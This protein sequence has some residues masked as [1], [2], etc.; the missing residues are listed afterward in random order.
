MQTLLQDLRFGLRMLAKNPGFTAVAMLTLAL[1]IGGTTAIFSVVYGAVLKPFPYRDSDR[2][3]MLTLH[4]VEQGRL[5]GVAWVSASELRAYREQ[6]H[7]FDEVIGG[8]PMEVVLTGSEIP[9]I[10]WA[11]AVTGNA[12][13]V[14]GVPPMIGRLITAED[15]RAGAPP[16]VLLS[17]EVWQAHFGGDPGIVGRT[18][19]LNQQPTTVIGVMPPRFGWQ[20][21][22]I[23]LPASVISSEPTDREYLFTMV[24]RLKQGV[25][26]DQANADVGV[27]AKR[28]ARIYPKDYSPET[29]V[30]VATLVDP[31]F[32]GAGK[33]FYILLGAVGVLLLIACGNVSNLL[34]SRATGREREFAVRAA[35]GAS[36][37][38]LVRQLLIEN[39][40]L[41]LGGAILGC[42]A[43]WNG[44]G[45]LMAIIPVVPETAVI[46]INGLVL[47]FTLGTAIFSTLLFGLVPTLLAVRK[48]LQ[49]Q[50]KASARGAGESRGHHRMRQVLVVSEVALSLVLLT[51]AGMLIRSYFAL[52]YIDLGYDP[53]HVMVAGAF[54]PPNQYKTPEQR[55]LFNM[56][57]LRRV[58]AL[59][60]VVSAALGGP[61]PNWAIPAT[62]EIE[63]KP[64][65]D[66]R[67][68]RLRFAGDG[69]F[70]TMRIRM[71]RGR[72]ISEEDVVQGRRVAVVSQTFVTS[73][74]GNENPLGRQ[75]KL[76]ASQ[77]VPPAMKQTGFE[78][79]GEVA[80]TRYI[81]DEDG[82]PTVEPTMF[83]PFSIGGIGVG[84]A[85]R[86]IGDP[87][88]LFKPVR[89]TYAAID[90]ELPVHPHVLRDIIKGTWFTEP[91]FVM[92]MLVAFASLGLTLVCI[93]VYSV[94]S[95]SVSQ[96]TNEIG[97][98]MALGAQVSEVRRMVMMS[99]LRWL[100]V[101]IGIGVLASIALAKILQNRI[102]GIKSAD[103]L[104]LVAVSLLLTLVG[105]AACY[106][107]ARRAT[108]VDPMV[109]LRYE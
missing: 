41:A 20:R 64:S 95:Y 8:S 69:F 19:I 38:R 22:E 14:L 9:E 25:S 29:T 56:E 76:V 7:V 71:L 65:S 72:G 109:A 106:F 107:P 91:Q 40:L 32:L 98:R 31:W 63:G 100:A 5:T 89:E 27:L 86:T 96:R 3:V 36:R 93:G 52:R 28:L 92:T 17:H 4:D 77:S 1:G 6:N 90:K 78:I 55:N 11:L 80:D 15:C 12:F 73:Y 46:R 39:L 68:V 87:V 58:R 23:W 21:G 34:L 50:L 51:G 2:L 48:D 26:L 35:L 70:E 47:L 53:D 81:G 102:W 13:R 61:A 18:L 54:L 66:N 83:V 10:F 97:I 24:G 103:P 49:A 108:K 94:L 101:G 57:A 74:F 75:I 16:V 88:N 105:L 104:T 33:T 43:A 30:R 62:V 85:V 79:I 82:G 60:G 42:L 84:V 59:P 44:L 99:G 67:R 37:G 45:S